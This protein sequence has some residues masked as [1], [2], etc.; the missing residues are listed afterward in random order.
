MSDPSARTPESTKP[1]QWRAVALP[2]EHGS[3]SFWLEPVLLGLLVA[4]SLAGAWLALASFAV[5]LTRQ[6]LKIAWIDHQR[7]RRY[8][9]TR[10]AER[11]AAGYLAIGVL[12]LAAAL[13]TAQD[14]AIL[15][16]LLLVAP[17]AVVQLYFDLRHESRHPLPEAVGPVTLA[18]VAASIALAGGWTLVPALALSGIII[19]RAVPTVFY[20]R[21]RLRLE[22]GQPAD[23][24]LSTLLHGLAVLAVAALAWARLAPPLSIIAALILL[25]RAVYGLSRFRR[26]ALPKHIGIQE[27]VFG[28]LVVGLA[29]AGYRPS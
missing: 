13:I 11:F 5:F 27:I 23:S 28:L 29:A 16:P 26:P 12:A 3:W 18:A 10:L 25:A 22:K 24:T 17:L 2:A 8:R 1:A 7:H 4:P 15:I 20:V 14:A 6:P 21:A 9:R 19:C